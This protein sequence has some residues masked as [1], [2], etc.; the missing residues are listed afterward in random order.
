[1]SEILPVFQILLQITN[2]ILVVLII[3]LSR[4]LFDLRIK[5]ERIETLLTVI[6][7]DIEKLKE[8]LYDGD[9][10]D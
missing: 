2:F 10:E 6:I 3:P 9:S 8:D 4:Y 1:M 7:K 5:I